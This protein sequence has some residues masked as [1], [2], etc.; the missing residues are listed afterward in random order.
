MFELGATLRHARSEQGLDV[1]DVAAATRIRSKYLVAFEDERFGSLPDEVYARAFIRTYA[2]FLGLDGELYAGELSARLEAA[3]PPPP[4]PPPEPRLRLPSLDRRALTAVGTAVGLVLVVLVAWHNGGGTERMP[5]LRATSVA[6]VETTIARRRAARPA[7]APR[8]GR[9][10]LAATRGD[11]WLTVRARSR[12]GRVLY[13]GL[14]REGSTVGVTGTRVWVRVGA[15]WN[16]AAS[17]N[18]R[19]LEGLPADTGNVVVTRDGIQPE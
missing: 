16:L 10:V 3:R 14:L 18:G 4:P 11:C 9:L 13:E 1:D 8:T 5:D 12:G 17:W 15:P 7:A 19:P 6:G 2:N